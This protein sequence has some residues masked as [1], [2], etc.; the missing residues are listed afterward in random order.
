MGGKFLLD[1]KKKEKE[2][3]IYLAL[4][5]FFF[6]IHLGM[7]G[8]TRLTITVIENKSFCETLRSPVLRKEA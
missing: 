4:R 6:L 2:S 1:Q 7:V 5:T 3:F 8:Q